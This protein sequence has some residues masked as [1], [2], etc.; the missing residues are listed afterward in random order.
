[1]ER[2]T[3]V[4]N[5]LKQLP[6]AAVAFSG[7]VDSSCLLYLCVQALGAENVLAVTVTSSMFPGRELAEAKEFASALGVR[8]ILI[9]AEEYSIPEFVE[10]G[11]RRCYYCKKG[12]FRKII[13]AAGELGFSHVLDGSNADDEGDYRPGKQ[14]LLELGIE[15]PLKGLK[16]EEIRCICAKYE[17]EAAK[18][19]SRACLASRIPYGT[20]ITPEALKTI[21]KAEELLIS[22]GYSDVRVRLYGDLARIELPKDCFI[23]FLHKTDFVSAELKKLGIRHAT[24]DIDGRVSGSMNA[25]IKTQE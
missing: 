7:G 20:P 9:P 8:H 14:A 1:M 6:N 19:P 17:L 11:P 3:L 24:L 13:A 23:D 4:I 5:T 2:E 21:E 12:I 22:L 18:M 10:N 15:S 16:K 25:G